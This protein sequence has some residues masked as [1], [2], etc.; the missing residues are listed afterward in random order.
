MKTR[1]LTPPLAAVAM[2]VILSSCGSTTTDLTPP[3]TTTPG[4]EVP[5]PKIKT[6]HNAPIGHPDPQGRANMII[7]PYRPYN[8]INVK[9]YSSGDI[10]GDPSTAKINP[11]TGKRDP[12]TAKLFQIP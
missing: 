7:S 4:A 6:T 3:G 5:A 1:H 8:L 2:A 10:V 11:K 9:G 12:S